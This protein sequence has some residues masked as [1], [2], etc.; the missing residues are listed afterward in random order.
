MHQ[1]R[2]L[3]QYVL[4]ERRALVGICALTV[5][6][7]GLTAVQPL[8]LKI[9]VDYGLAVTATP[10]T[11]SALLDALSVA[12][13]P[14]V[15]VV[16]A[17]VA[18]FVLFV[19]GAAL[20]TTLNWTWAGAGQRMVYGL[21][22]DLFHQL[23]RLSLRFHNQ[24]PVGDSLT[25]LTGDTWCAYTVAEAVLVAPAQHVLT[26]IT[27]G[28]VAWRLDPQLAAVSLVV[29][30][31]L[32]A[33]AFLFGTRLKQKTARDLEARSRLTAFVQQT[34]SAVKVV[35]AFGAEARNRCRFESLSGDTVRLAQQRSLVKNLYALGNGVALTAGIAAVLYL[36]GRRAL[37][38]QLSVGS[39]LVFIAYLQSLQRA[40]QGL[41][42]TYGNLR[43]SEAS[44]DRVFEVLDTEH[45]VRDRPGARPL[46][47]RPAGSRGHVR[48]ERVTF[49]FEPDRP[50][51]RE[52]T[53]EA[54]P[55]ETVALVGP[56][57]AGKTTLVSMIPRF[58][59]PWSGRVLIDGFDVREMQ[60]ASV[61]S[62]VALVLQE[63]FLLPL[64]VAQNI[65]YGRPDARDEEIIAAAAAAGANEF[66][67]ELPEGYETVLAEG[68]QT[69]SGG[70]RQRLA[71]ARALLRDAPILILDE[72]TSALDSHTEGA[73]LEAL[74]TLV[75]GRTT[76]VIAHRL[77]TIRNADRI[78]VIDGGALVESGTHEELMSTGGHYCR[79]YSLQSAGDR[80]EWDL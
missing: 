36:G 51:L 19:L 65:A 10:G 43:S 14:A 47:A 11:V 72:P 24:R 53:L 5:L 32:G 58:L 61:R 50:I 22:A 62:Q 59:D 46:P 29:A 8:P 6:T 60:L 16:A 31:I 55:G 80:M 64:T 2:R 3:L 15:V 70:Q 78:A 34:I 63:P 17:A 57:G 25:R 9:V 54:S 18:S 12:W 38:G 37:A 33:C 23:Q 39:L 13:S 45:E 77:S 79:G 21:A 27:V 4:R 26:L 56:T 76:L 48:L 75:T 35:Q 1:Y 41:L 68:G 67:C 40:S 52:V 20:E 30:P 7:S 66:I 42:R 49:G 74:R 71:I 73:V 69:L 44:V 28:F